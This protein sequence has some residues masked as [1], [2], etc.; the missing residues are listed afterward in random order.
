VN[1]APQYS[2]YA[3]PTSEPAYDSTAQVGSEQQF[4]SAQ[5]ACSEQPC[6]SVHQSYGE[7]RY[8]SGQQISPPNYNGQE[9]ESRQ[10]NYT[11][12]EYDS[13]QQNGYDPNVYREDC[14]PYG[15][16]AGAEATSQY[17]AYNP[18]YGAEYDPSQ[19]DGQV[20]DYVQES[21]IQDDYNGEVA[22]EAVNGNYAHPST[23]TTQYQ[24]YEQYEYPSEVPAAQDPAPAAES[25]EAQNYVYEADS[26]G[27]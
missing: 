23:E 16:E 15:S 3:E 21:F 1:E 7:E 22:A 9:Y 12:Q 13:S 25:F 18:N 24:S 10:Q 5:Q 27:F 19:F 2:S 17:D 26:S 14:N 6:D 20:Q 8:D 4:G 11:G